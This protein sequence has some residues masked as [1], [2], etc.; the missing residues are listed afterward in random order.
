LFGSALSGAPTPQAAA[1]TSKN[2]PERAAAGGPGGDP[3]QV[4]HPPPPPPI[5][6]ILPGL[7]EGSFRRN[8][9]TRLSTAVGVFAQWG[10]VEVMENRVRGCTT[11]FAFVAPQWLGASLLLT[12]KDSL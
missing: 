9:F 4:Q 10:V 5:V 2:V 6:G 12:V 3:G 11:G 7:L 8:V 1:L